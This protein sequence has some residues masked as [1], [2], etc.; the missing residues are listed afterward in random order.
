MTHIPAEQNFLS[1]S[2]LGIDTNNETV[3]F[4][5]KDCHICRAEGVASHT[6]VKVTTGN[7]S[8]VAS[9]NHVRGDSL[10]KPGEAGI[11][12]HVWKKYGLSPGAKL[13][14]SHLDPLD[15][16]SFVRSKVFGHRLNGMQLSRIIADIADDRYSNIH[17]SAFIS[18]CAAR[19]MTVEETI[20]LTRSMVVCGETLDWGKPIIA[21]KHCIGG[22]PGNRTTP[23]IVAIVAACGLTMP[24]TSSRA[25]TSPAGTA[26][27]ME[28]LTPVDLDVRTMRRVVEQ[29]GGC[30]VWG[31]SVS[32]SPADD[33]LIG[34]ER[35]LEIDSEGQLTASVLSKKIAAGSNHLI[36]D[37]PVGKTAKIRSPEDAELLGT[38]LRN[39][40][41]AFHLKTE[42]ITSDGSQPV[43][44]GI[45][46]ALE[47]RDVLFVLNNS[48]SAPKDLK[49]KAVQLAG[50]LLDLAGITLKG[51]GS[52]LALET[53]ENGAA[54]SKFQRICEAQ[55]GL[56][57]PPV[58]NIRHPLIAG[59][60]GIV[61]S[62][63]NRLLAKLAKLA[64]APDVPEAGA[65]YLVRVGDKIEAGRELVILHARSKVEL[66]YALDYAATHQPVIEIGDVL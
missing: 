5:R 21:D 48:P 6:R 44:R 1:L 52:R 32:L 36:L 51:D 2:R 12:E 31:G 20:E 14:V 33:I 59:R 64:G 43:G 53:L 15:S 27:M 38:L 10:L 13:T 63:D 23:I 22:L 25:I 28:V 42:I 49:V 8:F 62:V 26:D 35:A 9:V 45:G 50:A 55:G 18:A 58:A 61:R 16:L 46:P 19:G 3:L 40:A 17:I 29:E 54:W 7:S 24:K 66:Q 41:S 57:E 47:A 37:I 39:V 30:I 56:R 65:D 4:M 60:S 11:S 34:V